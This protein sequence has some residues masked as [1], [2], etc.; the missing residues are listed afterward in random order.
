MDF[1]LS[2]IVPTFNRLSSLK[3]C[4]DCL[5]NQDNFGGTF[6]VIVVDDGSSDGS[7][8]FLEK[9]SKDFDNFRYISQKNQGP[10]KARNSGLK[11]A[12]GSLICFIDDDCLVLSDWVFRMV[13]AHKVNPAAAA[14]GGYT[15]SADE[16]VSCLVGQ[17]LSNLTIK[18]KFSGQDNIIFFPTCNVSFKR[19]IFDE[20]IFDERFVTAG[21][22]DLEFFWRLFKK[23][24][25]FF[26]DKTIV[27]N[28]CRPSCLKSFFLQAFN[29]G[30]GNFL[31]YSIHSDHPALQEF[32]SY[33]HFFAS[34]LIFCKIPFF[35]FFLGKR[36]IKQEK[37]KGFFR[38]I[39]VYYF[40]SIHKVGYILGSISEYQKIKNNSLLLPRLLIV[41]VTRRCNLSCRVCNIWKQAAANKELSLKQI[42]SILDQA[43]QLGIKEIA[44]TGGEPLIREDIF[45]IFESAK[46][47][48]IKDLGIVTNG[49][50]LAEEFERVKP[51]LI[52]N[53]VMF[54]VSFD[55]LNPQLHNF[56]RNNDQAWFRTKET[57]GKLSALKKQFPNINFATSSIVLN[58]NLEELEDI[59]DY[60]KKIG[61]YWFQVQAFLPNN[62]AMTNRRGS[63]FWVADNRLP[64]LDIVADDLVSFSQKNPG[65]VRNSFNNLSLLKKYY[66][67]SLGAEDVNCSFGDKTVSVSVEGKFTTC[68]CGYG[69]IKNNS[70]KNILSS[71]ARVRAANKSRRCQRPCLVACFCDMENIS[72]F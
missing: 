11:I 14:V 63:S 60:V 40:F 18:S 49:I 26:W 42:T 58:D 54:I 5:L 37:I 24:Y 3:N 69:N 66:R 52:D 64:V 7:I 28:H 45:D 67:R 23:G 20:D 56:I 35:S 17:F 53:T 34:F 41:E 12:K 10:A 39:K 8:D 46:K 4:I 22:E 9:K 16:S 6:E 30:R 43:H 31:A 1:E 21:G 51:Y 32:C 70:L 68:F 25:R 62:F 15:V 72:C 27:V 2:V 59:A 50:I 33:N 29:Y 47:I 55:S 65:F 61:A 13:T 19:E 44:L 38:K 57:L 48:G 36:L 71:R